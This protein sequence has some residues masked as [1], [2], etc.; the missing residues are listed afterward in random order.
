M[1]HKGEPVIHQADQRAARVDVNGREGLCF[2]IGQI[3]VRAIDPTI[4]VGDELH[5]LSDLQPGFAREREAHIA[6]RA[7]PKTLVICHPD[8]GRE[9]SSAQVA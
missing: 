5:P 2:R 3:K 9:G 4:L 7:Q 6:R 8:D 1:C